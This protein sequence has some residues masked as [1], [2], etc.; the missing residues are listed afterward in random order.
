M[1][2]TPSSTGC[3]SA[4][5]VALAREAVTG[6]DTGVDGTMERALT[7]LWYRGG[8]AA[9]L[10]QPLAWLYGAVMTVRRDFYER[11]WL[12][13]HRV[14]RPVVVVGNLT[15]GGTGKTPLVAWLAEKLSQRGLSVGILSRGYGSS[16]NAPRAVEPSSSWREVG[17]EPLLLR[18]RTGCATVVATDRVAGARALIERGV[19]VIIADDGLQHLRLARNCEVV[20]IDGTRGFGNGRLLPAGPLREPVAQLAHA[21]L[22]VFN[23]A[24]EHESIAHLGLPANARCAQMTLF[25]GNAVPLD[26]RRTARALE[27]FRGQRVHAVAGIGNP[28]RFFGDLRGRGLDIIEHPFADHHPFTAADLDFGADTPVLMTEKD[29]VKCRAFA[30][31][32]LWYVPVTARFSDAHAAEVLERVVEK[33]GFSVKAK[34]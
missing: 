29:A 23:G 11:G 30:S 32:R 25:P 18:Q 34:G 15:V 3:S 17:D 10:L 24:P 4:R 26:G 8:P 27:S 6:H 33:L 31:A 13:S 5:D 22:V 28:V 1:G 7:A 9:L 14:A 21:D 12:P 20:V 2:T 19:D 16:A